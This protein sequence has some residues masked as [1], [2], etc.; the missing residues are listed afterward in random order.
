MATWLKWH[1]SIAYTT[2]IVAILGAV[3]VISGENSAIVLGILSQLLVWKK[4][5][6]SG[7]NL[8]RIPKCT[9]PTSPHPHLNKKRSSCPW[10]IR[11]L[12]I[13]SV[14]RNPGPS[15]R[16]SSIW[17]SFGTWKL[18][19][20][21]YIYSGFRSHGGDPPEIIQIYPKYIQVMDDNDLAPFWGCHRWF[22]AHVLTMPKFQ[23]LMLSHCC[24]CDPHWCISTLNKQIPRFPTGITEGNRIGASFFLK[25][26]FG[27]TEKWESFWHHYGWDNGIP[28]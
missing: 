24:V 3:P 2:I 9:R 5:Y 12:K 16:T 1:E 10:T 6:V 4:S 23:K 21:I 13:L 15:N 11:R 25:R 19:S 28:A 26:S 18:Y 20:Y 22:S 8:N 27:M 14:S 17:E 7:K